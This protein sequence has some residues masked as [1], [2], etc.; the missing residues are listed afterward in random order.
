ML[1]WWNGLFLQ[2]KIFAVIALPASLVLVWQLMPNVRRRDRNPVYRRYK[3]WP[4]LSL[5]GI[6]AFF[7]LGGWT[8]VAMQHTLWAIPAS[9][10]AGL[11]G[12]ALT[13][14]AL[15]RYEKT[16]RSKKQNIED[17][18]GRTVT[19]YK[20]VPPVQSGKGAVLITL[21]ERLVVMPAVSDAPTALPVG[22]TVVITGRSEQGALTVAPFYEKKKP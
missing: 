4:I 12:A 15:F 16:Y 10:A 14:W 8:G 13:A 11:L 3:H 17:V 5:K 18:C 7:A 21:H 6:C 2:Q 22:L 19:V 1:A 9:L 20:T